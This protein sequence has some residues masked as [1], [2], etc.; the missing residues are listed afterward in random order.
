MFPHTIT[1]YRHSV[2]NGADVYTRQVVKGVYWYG[3]QGISQDG[4][5]ATEETPVTII[6]SPETAAQYGDGWTI[7]PKDRV[8]KGVHP[9]I[10][11]FRDIPA[12]PTVVGV[13]DNRCGSAVDNITIKAK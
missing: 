5:G 4:K 7:V 1:I 12:A 3:G 8:M 9:E 6:T 10:T 2:E 13:E 11:A